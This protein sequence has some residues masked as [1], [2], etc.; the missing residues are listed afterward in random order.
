MHGLAERAFSTANA[1]RAKRGSRLLGLLP[2]AKTSSSCGGS[3]RPPQPSPPI[4]THSSRMQHRLR[5]VRRDRIDFQR[6][7]GA[8]MIAHWPPGEARG[9]LLAA[10]PLAQR[11]FRTSIEL[12]VDL[13]FQVGFLACAPRTR[14]SAPQPLTRAWNAYARVDVGRSQAVPCSDAVRQS[15][16]GAFCGPVSFRL[17]CDLGVSGCPPD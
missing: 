7:R 10:I 14:R 16:T 6:A 5:P 4:A 17:P 15:G 9:L 1:S 8:A 13:R 3:F 11:H 2:S 12:M